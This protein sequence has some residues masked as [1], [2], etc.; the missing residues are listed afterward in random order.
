MVRVRWPVTIDDIDDEGRC[1]QQLFAPDEQD[2]YGN[3]T[4]TE[5]NELTQDSECEIEKIADHHG[6]SRERISMESKTVCWS[7]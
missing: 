2:P 3:R 7:I 5:W 6:D 1:R 4:N